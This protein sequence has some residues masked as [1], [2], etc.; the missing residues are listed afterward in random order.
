MPTPLENIRRLREAIRVLEREITGQLRS[1]TG[2]CGV[3]LA[4]C[5]TL[6]ELDASGPLSLSSIAERF[7][8]DQS[9]LSRTVDGMVRSG[10]LKRVVN[11][12]DRRAVCVELA[13]LG[14]KKVAAIH[15]QCDKFYASLLN[16]LSTAQQKLVLD[17]V[18]AL[19][20]GIRQQ[21]RS[22]LAPCCASP[23]RKRQ[24]KEA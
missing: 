16:G 21:R 14:K 24:K 3:S 20:D 7:T 2:C 17:G 8:L 11:P 13:P 18:S 5:H 9:T 19:A 23:S 4:Q 6:L 10:H 15:S 22:S 1:E 12:D